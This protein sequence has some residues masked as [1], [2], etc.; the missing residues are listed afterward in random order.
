MKNVYGYIYKIENLINGKVY[1]GQTSRTFKERYGFNWVKNTHNIHLKNAINKYGENNFIVNEEFDVGFSK[2]ELDQ[3]EIFWID[4]YNATDSKYGYNVVI[5]G[6]STK[7]F[8]NKPSKYYD[9]IYCLDTGEL[10]RNLSELKLLR[11]VDLSVYDIF[12]VEIDDNLNLNLITKEFKNHRYSVVSDEGSFI[13]Y[14]IDNHNT[15]K[16]ISFWEFR[17]IK[18]TSA[19]IDFLNLTKKV[20]KNYKKDYRENFEDFLWSDDGSICY[21]LDTAYNI[22]NYGGEDDETF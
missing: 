18:D 2:D 19:Y 3:K 9:M 13:Y 5:G 7:T 10:F 1:I 17:N 6:G 20:D 14:E 21:Q 4:F 16:E 11:D 8:N 22:Y 12:K 15:K